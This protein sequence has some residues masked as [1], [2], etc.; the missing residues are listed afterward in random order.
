MSTPALRVLTNRDLLHYISSFMDFIPCQF[1]TKCSRIKWGEFKKG[2]SVAAAGWLSILIQFQHQL[3]FSEMYVT[4]HCASWNHPEVL[5][6]ENATGAARG[7]SHAM[8]AAARG[9]HLD[10]VKW[11]HINRTEGCTTDAMNRSA[12]YNHVEVLQWLHINRTEGCTRTAMEGAAWYGHLEIVKWLQI[13]RTE[14]LH[15]RR[16]I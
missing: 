6:W 10:V 11:L 9:G 2:N 13:N 1:H 8:D 14:F 15:S 16:V 5:K 12:S 4:D 3:K 7:Y